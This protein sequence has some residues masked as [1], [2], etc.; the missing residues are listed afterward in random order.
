MKKYFLY[1]VPSTFVIECLFLS[2]EWGVWTDLQCTKH[3]G[4]M[5]ASFTANTSS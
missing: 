1:D 3:R 5:L 2:V 4:T